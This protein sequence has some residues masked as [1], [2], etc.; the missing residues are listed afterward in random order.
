MIENKSQS[1]LKKSSLIN[2]NIPEI[3]YRFFDSASHIAII[4]DSDFK[5]LN[6]N[7]LFLNLLK[8]DDQSKIIGKKDSEV[9]KPFASAEQIEAIEASDR[10][11]ANLPTGQ[12]VVAEGSLLLPNNQ[13]IIFYSKKFPIRDDS[14][15]LLGIGILSSDITEFK[16]YEQKL[17]ES[18]EKLAQWIK[19]QD[20]TIHESNVNLQFMQHVFDNTLD[21][22]IIT[23]KKGKALQIN[24]AFT[25]ITG[26]TLDDIRGENPRVLK[27]N[28]HEPDFY[29]KMWETI[30]QT[31]LW[32]GELWNRR[33]SGEIY[34]Q[35]LCISAIYNS[36]GEITHYVGVNND[37]S[38]L[39]RKEDKIH[40]YAYHD[41]LT[42][43]P[44]RK[45]FTDR[46]RRAIEKAKKN[47]TQIALLYMD[48][49][50]FKKVN[51]SKGYNVGDNLLKQISERLKSTLKDSDLLARLGSD[52]FAIALIS[53]E[54]MNSIISF[55]QKINETMQ[56]PFI[57]D[58]SEIFINSSIGIAIFPE[59]TESP[60]QLILHADT[61]MHQVKGSRL[62]NF[63]FYTSQ[64]K[65]MAQRKIDMESA[66]R[67]GLA[68]GEFVPFYQAKVSC[69]TG[70]IVG[71]EALA[72]WVKADGKIVPP[73]EFITL[74]EELNLIHELDSSIIRQAVKDMTIWESAGHDNLIVSVNVSAKELE[75]P[76]FASTIFEILDT[77]NIAKEKLEI[78]ITESLL[79]N[80]VEK[81]TH[82]LDKLC[83]SGISCSIDDF[84]TGYSSLSYLKKLPIKTLKIDGSFVND[85]MNDHNDLAIVCA[86]I[87]MAKH[88]GL[89][90]V[91]EGVED[92][93]QV[94]LLTKEGCDLIQGYYYSKPIPKDEFLD[95]LNAE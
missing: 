8:I 16:S 14:G 76:N 4:K 27:S 59:D 30:E 81:N 72:R 15:N 58:G 29:K 80:D 87:S 67:K 92:L 62:D 38:E 39:K 88:M 50:D 7:T 79:M 84:G 74:A 82:I 35:R 40:F 23:D 64:M 91:A 52:E 42:N 10:K 93:D 55:A 17:Q 24:P 70:K 78:E 83:S 75:D 45:L 68:N 95:F 3:L 11:A 86:I 71:M 69:E 94:E 66:I 43:L 32:S 5:Y 21:G 44:N 25:E 61:A 85:I 73:S 28:Y 51:D 6:I 57:I 54:N 9:L 49:D 33:K 53:C 47:N 20:K 26:Y 77:S 90:V 12:Y 65:V 56:N 19:T 1:G 18:S 22:I 41:V 48:L 60:D 37:L 46:L 36:D 13:N 34:P 2:K 89:K 31:G 63:R